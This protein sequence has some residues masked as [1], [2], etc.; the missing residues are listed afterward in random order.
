MRQARILVGIGLMVSCLI[1]VP[2]Q[3]G[4]AD[5][6]TRCGR[7]NI[8]TPG[9]GGVDTGMGREAVANLP[10][11]PG[12]KGNSPVD[13]AYTGPRYEYGTTVACTIQ[14]PGGPAA[15]AMCSLAI[16]SCSDPTKGAGP[17]TRIWQRT[18]QTTGEVSGW[19]SIGITC[20][21]D[22][23]PGSRPRVTMAMIIDAF[24]HTRVTPPG[25][26]LRSRPSRQA[27]SPSSGWTRITR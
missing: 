26:R 18:V 4:N 1:L 27:T 15:E 6:S 7:L 25:R 23:A 10:N 12:E 5:P 14:P 3:A 9:G 19:T 21:A 16:T 20:W 8:C 13:A 17:L 24:R 22:V 2:G 11:I